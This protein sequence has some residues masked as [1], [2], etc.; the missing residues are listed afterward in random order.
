[1]ISFLQERNRFF[2]NNE[3]K[4]QQHKNVRDMKNKTKKTSTFLHDQSTSRIGRR[5]HFGSIE[6]SGSFSFADRRNKMKRM[7]FGVPFLFL[8]LSSTPPHPFFHKSTS[9]KSSCGLDCGRDSLRD[10]GVGNKWGDRRG[11]WCDCFKD[12]DSLDSIGTGNGGGG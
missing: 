9:S 12:D 7:L 2:K 3:S 10:G 8:C 5:C 6:S 11:G 4:S 1:M